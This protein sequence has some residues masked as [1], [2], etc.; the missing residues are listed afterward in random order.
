MDLSTDEFFGDGSTTAGGAT[1]D[2][3]E[4]IVPLIPLLGMN[5]E[6]EAVPIS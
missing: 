5:G 2:G 6:G 4:E 3:E 1:T